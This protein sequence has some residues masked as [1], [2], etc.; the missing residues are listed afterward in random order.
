M[1]QGFEF[2]VKKPPRASI[3]F[4]DNAE[5]HFIPKVEPEDYDDLFYRKEEI[6][7]F[8]Y[9]AFYDDFVERYKA[10]TRGRK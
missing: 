6:A 8:R 1:P 2:A 10:R 9:D 4:S 3:T 7:K 5:I